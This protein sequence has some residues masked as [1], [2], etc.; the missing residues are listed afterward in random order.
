MKFTTYLLALGVAGALTPC[1]AAPAKSAPIQPA[2]ASA[3]APAASP[4]PADSPS[5]ATPAATPQSSVTLVSERVHITIGEKEVHVESTSEFVN[6]GAACTVG[7]GL[8]DQVRATPHT[9]A[10]RIDGR[11]TRTGVIYCA[12]PNGV[13]HERSLVFRNHGKHT[14][15]SEYTLPLEAQSALDGSYYQIFYTL[16]DGG[17]WP[18]YIEHSEVEITFDRASVPGKLNLLPTE[19][20]GE[21]HMANVQWSH[22][23]P[24]TVVFQ[25]PA[26]P[27]K[28]GKTLTFVRDHW[29]PAPGDDLALF[30]KE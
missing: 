5:S 10:L 26:T 7:I 14:V 6:H 19:I 27:A 17:T 2:A 21:S 8:P 13:W 30:W 12:K 4:S 22:F 23:G 16:G 25:A 9:F 20:L 15:H 11:L 3:P 29:K 18:D 24:G 1:S 28:D